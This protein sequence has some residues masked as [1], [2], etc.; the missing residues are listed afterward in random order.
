MYNEVAEDDPF[1]K[2]EASDTAVYEYVEIW[3]LQGSRISAL[4]PEVSCITAVLIVP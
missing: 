2:V 1:E 4:R 3:G